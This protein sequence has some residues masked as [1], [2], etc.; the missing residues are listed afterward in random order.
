MLEFWEMCVGLGKPI[1]IDMAAD[2]LRKLDVNCDGVVDIN[3]FKTWWVPFE[4]RMMERLQQQQQEQQQQEEVE[5]EAAAEEGQGEGMYAT[6]AQEDVVENNNNNNIN[7]KSTFNAPE[8]PEPPSSPP[9]PMMQSSMSMSMSASSIDVSAAP[10][11]VPPISSPSLD[12]SPE[13]GA[14]ESSIDRSDIDAQFAYI[15]RQSR[16]PPNF[17][18][19]APLL[20]MDAP[21]PLSSSPVSAAMSPS[22]RRLFSSKP[23]P[24]PPLHLLQKTQSALDLM[25]S[26][27]NRSNVESTELYPRAALPR[28]SGR[29]APSKTEPEP[30][31]RDKVPPLDM[32]YERMVFFFLSI[33]PFLSPQPPASA[34]SSPSL[35]RKLSRAI[36]P[37]RGRVNECEIFFFFFR[38]I[39]IS[40]PRFAS[41][42]QYREPKST[43]RHVTSFS[44]FAAA[45]GR[46]AS[47]TVPR[48]LR[49]CTW[50]SRV[51]RLGTRMI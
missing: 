10:S 15:H 1:E 48:A 9:P 3:E 17:D 12:S 33:Y 46:I 11:P 34:P 28:T 16:L 5:E 45:A 18:D 39:Y 47:T 13:N 40:Q 6:E 51:V 14:K 35:L 21:S 31:K 22:T 41:R 7:E 20:S 50:R 37:K 32:P 4:A 24:K 29:T 27:T 44:N 38:F 2:A 43:W 19:Y 42:R 36:S 25:P 30:M 8:S 23:L 26:V 49:R